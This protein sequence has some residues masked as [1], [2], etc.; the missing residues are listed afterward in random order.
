MPLG[1]TSRLL[2]GRDAALGVSLRIRKVFFRE[3]APPG[4]LRK[5]FQPPHVGWAGCHLPLVDRAGGTHFSNCSKSAP[6][7]EFKFF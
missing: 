4:G 7:F 5:F 1:G 3:E 6:F 2:G